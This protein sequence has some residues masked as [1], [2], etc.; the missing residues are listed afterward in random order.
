M[1]P[2][3]KSLEILSTISFNTL[4]SNPLTFSTK[5]FPKDESNNLDA[6]SL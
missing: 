3:S 2:F 1:T 4:I 5:T 6:N